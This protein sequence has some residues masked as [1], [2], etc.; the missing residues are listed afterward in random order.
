MAQP[1]FLNPLNTIKAFTFPEDMKRHTY[2]H[3]HIQTPHLNEAIQYAL[4]RHPEMAFAYEKGSV[5]NGKL[6]HYF[7]GYE[8]HRCLP[9]APVFEWAAEPV[10]E[11]VKELICD[12]MRVRKEARIPSQSFE[13]SV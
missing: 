10:S 2:K 9:L 4:V 7:H 8:F 6:N 3:N 11:E 13:C 1:A 12:E 5:E